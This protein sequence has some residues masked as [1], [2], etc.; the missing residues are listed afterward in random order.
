MAQ[1][2]TTLIALKLGSALGALMLA[3]PAMAQPV[4]DETEID[5]TPDVG[6]TIVV[7]ARRTEE[8][9]EDVPAS[10]SAFDTAALERIQAQDTTGLQGAVPNLNI[11]QGRG[12]SNATN[13]FIRGVG[14]PDALQ[15]FDPAVGV[16]VDDVYLSRI[17]GTQLD[18]L[19]LER[20]EVLRGP[21]GT[22][23][24]KNTIGG[25]L[26]LVSRRPGNDL[27]A[28]F[29]VNYGT[30]D[31]LDLRGSVSG[32]LAEG[33]SAGIA[34]M[35]SRRDGFV[36]DR[37]LARDYNDKDT[38]ALRGTLALTP[39]D[40]FRIDLSADYSRDDASLNVGAPINELRYL[41]TG[42]ELLPLAVDPEDYDYTA[43][44]TPGL[45]NSTKL[46]HWGASARMEWDVGPEIQLRSITAYRELDTDDYIDIDATE[47]EVGDVFVGVDQNQFSQ[48][49][50]FVYDG[51]GFQAVAGLYYLQ[52][53]ITSD[54]RA[55]ADDLVDLRGFRAVNALPPALLGPDDFPT[56]LR[57]IADDLQTDSYA[58]Y[59][60]VD[61]EL[62]DALTLAAGIRYTYEQKDYF[63]TTST[64]SSAPFLNSAAP[65]EFAPS[66][67]WDDV[68]PMASLRY[69]FSPDASAYLRIAKGFKSG[70]FNGRANSATETSAYEPETVLSYEAGFK[71]SID[72]QIRLAGAVFYNDYE[73]FQARVS[74]IE[75]DP[76]TNVPTPTLGVL[77]AGKLEI[78]GAELE[79]A[80]T[81]TR[82]FLLDAQIGYLDAKYDEFADDRF[83]STN[84]SRAFQTPAFAPDWTI[85]L[86]SQ[87]TFEFGDGSD[88]VI[89]AQ[90]KYRSEYALS[91]DNTL[92]DST[93]RIEGLFE[94][95]YSLVDARVEWTAP[96]ENYTIGVYGQNLFDELY[97]T[98][99][100][101]FS[102]IGNIRT[103]YFGAPRTV[104]LRLTASF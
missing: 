2:K 54:Q 60:N 25:A 82:A 12:S 59:A 94:D 10:V 38:L 90:Y 99:G 13:I 56:F 23:Y 44:T 11:V 29:G 21:Q 32:P 64:F 27:R 8:T 41:F 33:V 81:P 79:V 20:V 86:G 95:G 104:Y 1:T 83:A 85:R 14:Q 57:T 78:S 65:F 71:A 102:S 51:V 9:L 7:T 73:D 68:S 50:Q 66:D 47:L 19:D 97:K 4:P 42:L 58:A 53:N 35:Y 87:Y 31:Q 76:I 80:W 96:G 69:E 100:Q 72:G 75:V 6:S 93:T 62:T 92:I 28:N 88:L 89:G 37:V 84:G 16:Y 17:R 70:G 3:V 40:D 24:G 55:F 67:S 34:A 43:R 36:E 46:D 74:G 61:V 48:E 49:F 22:L 26:K 98:D 63:R 15:T 30:F 5:E 101:E 52:E 18:L 103:V 91:V 45:P 39:S 77:N